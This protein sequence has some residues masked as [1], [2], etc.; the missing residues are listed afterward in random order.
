M[1]FSSLNIK[2][3][4]WV[5]KVQVGPPSDFNIGDEKY[6]FVQ[7]RGPHQMRGENEWEVRDVDKSLG[8]SL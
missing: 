1:S 6:S 7:G 3:F 5:K 2:C 8:I 4:H